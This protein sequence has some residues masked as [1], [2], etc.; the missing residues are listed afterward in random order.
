L[1]RF[2]AVI[3]GSGLGGLLSAVILA[4]EGM[5]VCVLEKDKQIGGCLQTFSVQKTVFDSCVH[6]V[7]GLGEGHT[8]N[9]I[10][11]YAG[12][13]ERLDLRSFDVNGFDR[14]A[15]EEESILYP[16][17]I[18]LENFVEQ[19]VP[20]FP[21]EN[22]ALK[23]Y[24]KAVTTVGD[25]FPLYRLRAGRAEEKA[26][27]SSWPLTGTLAQITDNTHLQN[28]L[29]GN[30]LLYAGERARSPF[31]LHALVLGRYMHS[32]HKIL[33]GSSQ[34]AK[35]LW[36]ELQLHGGTIYRNTEVIKLVE[37]NGS[38]QYAEVKDGRRFHGK[39]FI[40]NIHP[41][42]LIGML[43]SQIIR[44]AYKNRISGLQQTVSAFMLNLVLKPGTVLFRDY[45][46]YWHA[47]QDVWEAVAYNSA[48]W[49]ANYALYF[50]ESTQFP[51][52]AESLSILTYMHYDEVKPWAETTNHSGDEHE[53]GAGYDA[54][55]EQKSERLLNKVFERVPE[56][57]GNII[58]HSAATPL[59]YRDYTGTPE[60]A[61]YGILKDVNK[62]NETTIATRTKIPNLLLT[63]QN[64]NLHGVLGVSITA[65]ATCAE[66]LGLDY[67]LKK[68]NS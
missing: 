60:G 47:K 29:A 24:V 39:Q 26:A 57:R 41:R 18:G 53:R 40:A 62:P 55:K 30:N 17:A 7:G 36:K 59:T 37:E 49:P 23:E 54:F 27:V 67:L 46:L 66:L 9:R 16:Q 5:K 4:K 13:M 25:H 6:Y 34:I 45:N 32:A 19:L 63:G 51:G 14:I 68:V 10:F 61:L 50:T 8:L 48:E 35:Y 15:F 58:A 56:L 11:T 12:I 2:D 33:P 65:V 21:K 1:E 31:Y 20:H 22:E 52:Y 43:Q 3:I 44:P 64:V 38:L 28:V 42:V